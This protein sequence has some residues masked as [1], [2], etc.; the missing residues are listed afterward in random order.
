MKV[1]AT[2]GRSPSGEPCKSLSCV[3][4]LCVLYFCFSKVLGIRVHSLQHVVVAMSDSRHFSY[5]GMFVLY[6][7]L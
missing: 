5:F 2:C 7:L 3:I 4:V 6:R 1:V